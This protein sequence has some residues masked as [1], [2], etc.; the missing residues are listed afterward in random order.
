MPLD[1]SLLEEAREA[2][3]EYDAEPVRPAIAQAEPLEIRLAREYMRLA[4]I[5]DYLKGLRRS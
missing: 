2:V 4:E 5:E 1:R 3:L